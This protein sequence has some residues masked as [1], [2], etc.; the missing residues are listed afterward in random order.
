MLLSNAVG[1][2]LARAAAGHRV[3]VCGL[4]VCVWGCARFVGGSCRCSTWSF[5]GS[6]WARST[7]ARL[8]G[9]DGT[10]VVWGRVTRD[11]RACRV[12]GYLATSFS[13]AVACVFLY[14][15]FAEGKT[16]VKWMVEME[17]R[18]RDDGVFKCKQVN[19]VDTN[20]LGQEELL[21]APHSVFTV[22]QLHV[23]ANTSDDDPVTV[24]CRAQC[25]GGGGAGFGGVA[26]RQAQ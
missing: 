19:F 15:K 18:G 17:A 6:E 12:P 13:E 23:P 22:L 16:A 25:E 3:M 7:G 10:C 24:G 11:A 9:R 1:D 14:S 20:A 26:L 4:V 2:A 5:T 8:R 21:F